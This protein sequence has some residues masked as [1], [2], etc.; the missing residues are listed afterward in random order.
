M[1]RSASASSRI[2]GH[3]L[4]VQAD[5]WMYHFDRTG[6]L[7]LAVGPRQVVRRGLDNRVVQVFTPGIGPNHRIYKTFN[8]IEKANFYRHAY[9]I[10]QATL[11]SLPADQAERWQLLL[12]RWSPETLA[13]DE[14]AFR[15]VYLPISILPPDQYRALVVQITHGCSYNRCLFCDFYRDRRFHIKTTEELQLHLDRLKDFMGPRIA[16]RTGI[17]LADGNA[18][19]VPTSRLLTMIELIRQKFGTTV[20]Q[21]F[22]TFMDTFTLERKSIEDLRRIYDHGLRT[23]YTGLETGS[24]RLRAFLRKPGTAEEAVNALN[25]LK[26]AGFRLGTILLVGVGGPVFADE[27]LYETLKILRL[28]RFTREDIVFLSP[29]VE[30]SQTDYDQ[31]ARAEGLVSFTEDEID[32]ELDLWRD[33]LRSLPA[34][35]T[36]YSVK[37]HLYS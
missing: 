10:A 12:S 7:L 35:I 6:R 23:V 33:A 28:I 9:E 15:N 17:F 27:H 30:P 14:Q 31:Q 34:K 29:F 8:P 3:R 2:H 21:D 1:L 20:S 22:Y 16:D 24:N 18:F 11:A 26:D 37:E 5:D 32:R 19:V 13:A 36:L 4:I 25:T